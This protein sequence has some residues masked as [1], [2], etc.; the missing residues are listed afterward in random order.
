MADGK[1]NVPVI[2][3]TNKST[4]FIAGLAGL[5]AL[6][7]TLWKDKKTKA[8]A[9]TANAASAATASQQATAAS[10]YGYG[11]YAFQPYGYGY[12]PEGLGAYGG[13]GDYG[14]GYYGAGE[15]V[16][17]EVPAAAATNAQWSEAA[18]TALTAAGWTGA[19]VLTA[20]GLYITGSPVSATQQQIIQ[21]AIAAEGYPPAPGAS[22]YPPA[23]NTG[24]ST[25]QST[26]TPAAG[27]PQNQSGVISGLTKNGKAT[28]MNVT[29][30]NAGIT[31][32]GPGGLSPGFQTGNIHSN[33]TNENADVTTHDG[34]KTWGFVAGL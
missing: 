29:T 9:S 28:T 11:A 23:I 13:Q 5:T 19:D 7:W 1:I 30:T 34:G 27:N 2:G 16:N 3:E 17:E 22:G 31:W 33:T 26:T 32:T 12:G 15:P 4:L 8:A 10:G 18:M 25:G 24:P 21:A 20:L 6:G 14:Y